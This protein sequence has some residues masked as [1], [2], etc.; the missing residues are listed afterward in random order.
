MK[1]SDSL[2]GRHYSFRL[3]PFSMREMEHPDV[4][5]PDE[6]LG[7]L[8]SRANQGR[9]A[10]EGNLEALMTYGPFP[11]PLLEQNAR[12]ANLWRRNREQLI[13]RED[14]RDLSRLLELGR[15]E[16]MTALLP[17]RVGSLFSPTALA[18]DLE[19]S[20]PTIKRWTTYLKQLYYLFELK[21]YTR[22]IV[23]SLRRDGKIYL[24][25][26]GAIKD[27]AARFENLVACHLLK[28]CNFWTDTG[29]G[30][31]ELCLLRNKDGQE[32]DFLILRDGVSWLPVCQAPVGNGRT[33]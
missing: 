9:K 17:E 30:E 32:I 19:V 22:H 18:Q 7:T 3:H 14:L 16:L 4:L 28:T 33:A 26:Y 11:E 1:G 21:P 24:W 13:V 10:P 25:D 12:K 31:F 15:I 5:A 2:L 8:F 6:M 27:E 20:I 29:E 23:R